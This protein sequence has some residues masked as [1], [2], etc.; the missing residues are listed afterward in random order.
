MIIKL[1]KTSFQ[2]MGLGG[3][4]SQGKANYRRSKTADLEILRWTAG[5]EFLNVIFRYLQIQKNTHRN[6]S[7][8][9]EKFKV[10]LFDM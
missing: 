7:D 8:E 1:Q 9:A 2:T 3:R 4:W 10:I 5:Y 6:Q